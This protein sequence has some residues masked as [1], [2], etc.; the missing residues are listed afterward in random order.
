MSSEIASNVGGW[1]NRADDHVLHLKAGMSNRK[2][3]K[4]PALY[5]SEKTPDSLVRYLD[6]LIKNLDQVVR[7]NAKSGRA[8]NSTINRVLQRQGR[9]K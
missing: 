7:K 3:Y 5:R 1:A 4:D 9:R 6:Q 2:S 8:K